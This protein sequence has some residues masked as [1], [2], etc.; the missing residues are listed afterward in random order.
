[1]PSTQPPQGLL[2]DASA[3]SA[4]VRTA[5]EF[6]IKGLLGL[7]GVFSIAITCSIVVVLF[8]E[9]VRFFGL[10]EV[11]LNQFFLSTEWNPL[12][13][14]E[15]PSYGVWPLITGTLLVTLIAACVA[16][17]LGVISAIYLSEYA[18][19]KVRKVLKPTL[20][21][22][23][24]IP[25]VVYGFFALT[26]ITPAL[27]SFFKAVTGDDVLAAFNPI[28]AG[29]A[30]GVMCLPM[31]SSLSE[32]ALRAV[33]KS[34][35]EGAY[36]MGAT[37]FDVAVKVVV[38]AALSGIMASFLL[39][40]ARAIG[41]TMIV[42]MAAGSSPVI[43]SDPTQ[44]IQTMTGYMVQ[45]FGGDAP[46]GSANYYSAYAIGATLFVITLSITLLGNWI[47]RRYREVYD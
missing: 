7:C 30:V 39:A 31:V 8:T 12:L 9:A 34:L 35:R 45:I 36:G 41:E 40:I 13:N 21:I 46:F 20:E 11:S 14:P 16:L 43:A 29:I 23:A 6:C 2:A 26:V 10:D 44:S 4:R 47:L 25:T 3:R 19:P 38:P 5:R 33:P 42:S 1:M 17:P 27:R 18:P 22:L 24:G 32:D 15:D 37:R 28:S